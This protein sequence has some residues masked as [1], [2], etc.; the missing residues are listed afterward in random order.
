MQPI[1][2]SFPEFPEDAKTDQ[3]VVNLVSQFY[4]D[5]D[6]YHNTYFDNMREY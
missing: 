1:N 2:N 5:S 6:E 4:R 3:Q